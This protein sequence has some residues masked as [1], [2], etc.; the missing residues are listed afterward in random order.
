[1]HAM[2]LEGLITKVRIPNKPEFQDVR[3]R[4]DVLIGQ[5]AAAGQPPQPDE[6]EEL[7]A[8]DEQNE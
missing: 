4:I 2:D 1:M 7:P 8:L 5:L 6:S 3:D